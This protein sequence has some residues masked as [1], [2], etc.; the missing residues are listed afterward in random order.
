MQKY[1][2]ISLFINLL[3]FLYNSNKL[4][5]FLKILIYNLKKLYKFWLRYK[6]KI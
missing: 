1:L 2:N 3:Y 4:R 5:N 6:N